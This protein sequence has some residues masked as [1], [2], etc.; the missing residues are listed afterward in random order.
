M[1]W[2]DLYN[3]GM[4]KVNGQYVEGEVRLPN[5]GIKVESHSGASGSAEVDLSIP[6]SPTG[7]TAQGAFTHVVLQWTNVTGRDDISHTEVHRNSD[8]NLGT[9][10]YIGQ[11]TGTLFSDPVDPGVTYYYWVRHVSDAGIAGT[12]N[13]TNGVAASTAEDPAVLLAT[14]QDSIDAST[15]TAELNTRLNKIETTESGLAQEVIDRAAAV[16]AESDARAAGDSAVAQS[17]STL[18]TTVDGHTSTLSTHGSTLNGLSGQYTVKLDVNGNVAGYGL[19]SGPAQADGTE[20]EFTVLADK[21]SVLHPDA[22]DPTSPKLAFTVHNGKTVM[23]GAY[24]QDATITS[25]KI[26][27]L[28]VDKIIGDTAAFVSANIENA[29]IGSAKIAQT[30]QS[31]NY[32][33][34]NGWFISKDGTFIVRKL[35]ASGDIIGARVTG[36][37]IEGG[38]FIGST[39]ITLPTEADIGS[40]PRFVAYTVGVGGS[41]TKNY[42]YTHSTEPS[43]SA[44]SPAI[45]LDIASSAYT[46]SGTESH[47]DGY[48]VYTPYNRYLKNNVDPHITI[49]L[50]KTGGTLRTVYA[51]G[52]RIQIGY[53]DKNGVFNS[54]RQFDAFTPSGNYK[55]GTWSINNSNFVGTL[56][57]TGGTTTLYDNDGW[58]SGSLNYVSGM[59]VEGRITPMSF[60]KS[61]GRKVAFR[62]RTYINSGE[63]FSSSSFTGAATIVDDQSRYL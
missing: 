50:D 24:I 34:T 48:L 44:Y 51:S 1:T 23:S 32:D 42:S 41:N 22:T 21:F 36:S 35:Q 54:I 58:P 14:L 63:H 18:S 45:E 6:G 53:L 11:A 37:V 40:E 5:T 55:S 29:S 26:A 60:T 25:A 12:Y 46:A 33:A 4:V 3:T 39:I 43:W 38:L 28:S 7:L 59:R 62:W 56:T 8:D 10:V 16:L 30:L 15:L 20:S 9:A 52:F 49:D 17:V 2:R 47:A 57:L 61:A 19:A 27:S 13:A 31:D